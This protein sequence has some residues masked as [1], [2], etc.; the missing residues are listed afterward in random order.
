MKRKPGFYSKNG[1]ILAKKERILE[2]KNT[3]INHEF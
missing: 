2:L 1:G 3:R